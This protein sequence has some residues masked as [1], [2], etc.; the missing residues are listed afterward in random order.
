MDKYNQL[1]MDIAN[2]ITSTKMDNEF[3]RAELYRVNKKLEQLEM[4]TQK[5]GESVAE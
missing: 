3:L 1:L 4:E 5:G 2:L